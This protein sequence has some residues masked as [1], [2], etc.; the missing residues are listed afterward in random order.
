MTT[1]DLPEQTALRLHPAPVP[2]PLPARL[3]MRLATIVTG[4]TGHLD[5]SGQLPAELRGRPYLLVA[6]HIG[7]F[8]SGVLLAACRQLGIAPR[9]LTKAGL[10]DTP[11]LGPLLRRCGHHAV[12]QQA[13]GTVEELALR[14]PSSGPLLIYPEGRIS[15]DPGL[16]PERGKT[17]AARLALAAKLPVLTLSQ[18]GAHEVIPWATP[19]VRTLPDLVRITRIW[20]GASSR[21]VEF[22]VRLGGPVDLTDLRSGRPGDA[23]RAHARIMQELTDGLATLRPDEPDLPQFCDPSRPHGRPSPWRPQH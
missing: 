4:M 16:W 7:I 6:N 13:I 18:W 10:L 22:R 2:A 21:R 1:S 11:V 23:R 5:V 14:S 15:L 12:D 8:D 19:P 9:F 3:L 20:L 17:G